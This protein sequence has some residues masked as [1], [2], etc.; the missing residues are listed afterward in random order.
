TET[1]FAAVFQNLKTELESRCS[2]EVVQETQH[3][4]NLLERLI[5]RIFQVVNRLTGVRI[6]NVQVPDITFEATSENTADVKIP[7]TA[8]ITVNRPLLGEI[9]DLDL[10]VNLQTSVSVETDPETGDSKVVVGECINNSESISLTVRHR[11]FG[12][13]SDVVDFGVDIARRVVSSAVQDELCPRIRELLESLD[14]ECVKKL[15][16]EPQESQEELDEST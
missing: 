3:T 2:E 12:L 7:I 6:R 9:V 10:N 5:S 1:A 13:L 4:E 11:R 8:D 16:G 15:I 14:A